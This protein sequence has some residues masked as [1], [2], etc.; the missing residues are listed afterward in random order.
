MTQYKTYTIDN[1]IDI[2]IQH[3]KEISKVLGDPKDTRIKTLTEIKLSA[4]ILEN[5]LPQIS[6][7]IKRVINYLISI[8]EQNV[9]YLDE[10]T[11]MFIRALT[12]AT[13][14]L[15]NHRRQ[16]DNKL[17][18]LRNDFLRRYQHLPTA[19]QII[20]KVFTTLIYIDK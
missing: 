7:I 19:L 5:Q 4:I 15:D 8:T 1:K 11:E 16:K 12:I 13:L 18:E 6:H 20:R 10:V 2:Y 14:I 9:K 17:K 3:F